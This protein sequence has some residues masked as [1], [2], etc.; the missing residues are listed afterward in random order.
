MDS[1][2]WPPPPSSPEHCHR[3]RNGEF[4]PKEGT[5]VTDH[6]LPEQSRD[7]LNQASLLYKEEAQ[8]SVGWGVGG[9][10]PGKLSLLRILLTSPHR[11]NNR[12]ENRRSR[13][14]FS[15]RVKAPLAPRATD[16]TESKRDRMGRGGGGVSSRSIPPGPCRQGTVSTPQRAGWSWPKASRQ[17]LFLF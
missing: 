16:D 10:T 1:P 3:V 14:G 17:L 2:F 13:T 7:G 5:C 9:L 6:S 12:S 8:W 15:W 11:E 4:V